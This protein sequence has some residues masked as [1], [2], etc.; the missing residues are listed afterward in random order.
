MKNTNAHTA[1]WPHVA[2]TYLLFWYL[3]SATQL[4]LFTAGITSLEGLKDTTLTSIVWLI[5]ILLLPSHTKLVSAILGFTIWLFALP[6]IGYFLI[7][8]Q[9]LSQSLIFI[10][11]ESNKAESSEYLQNYFNVAVLLK[12]M[13]FTIIPILIWRR[14]P[15]NLAITYKS[16][17]AFA[18][19]IA[20][21][22]LAYPVSKA[23]SAS[24]V[25][26][27]YKKLNKH[28]VSAPPWQL[29]LGYLNYQREL[30]EVELFLT[31]FNQSAALSHFAERKKP[32]PTTV[33]VVIG[34][35]STRLHFSLYGYH[36]N[37]NPKLSTIKDELSIFKNVYASRPNTIESLQQVLSFADQAQPDLYKTKP[38]LV[39]MMK[40][41]G[42]KTFWI[43]N[44]QTL[45]ARNTILTTFAKQT[46][47]Q[48]WLNNARSQNSY[49]FDEKVLAP[50]SQT[51]NDKAQKKFIIV[52]L[53]GSHMSYK[54]RYPES[55]NYFKDHRNLY[56]G[57]SDDK[58]EKINAYDNAIRYN[59][60][61]VYALIQRLKSTQQH[62]MLTYFSDH[63]DDVY[64]SNNHDFQGRN[65]YAPTLPMYAV[66]F[67]TWTSRNWF[68]NHLL[69]NPAILDRHYSNADFIYTWSELMGISYT[70]FDATKSILSN[71]FMN[72]PIV[73]GNPYDAKSLTTLKIH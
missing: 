33:V 20:I 56:A 3:S 41:A 40:Q 13:I 21:C 32:Q 7:Y 30:K 27:A 51:L 46:D 18:L 70:G 65:E 47:Q 28:L 55:F 68:S 62:S 42:Y 10:I 26:V 61:I 73:I 1:F 72:R 52:H 71:T 63:G 37:T 48:I 64:D 5:P 53:I 67:I 15:K 11:F 19:M 23:V 59:D 50:F 9:E 25:S 14:I 36:R 12:V 35:S 24:D 4:L 54:Y 34:E 16:G 39:A 69:K 58:I 2:W 44:Q 45:T 17:R 49:S 57:L 31:K 38:T 29:I 6:A 60:S 22:F 66:P 43:S 8:Q